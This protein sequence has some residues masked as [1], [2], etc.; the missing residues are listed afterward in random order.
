MSPRAGEEANA[1]LLARLRH[2]LQAPELSPAQIR[3]GR[4]LAGLTQRDLAK[5]VGVS[6]S[7]IR[8]WETGTRNPND[9][10]KAALVD[11]LR[12]S[13]VWAAGGLVDPE[14]GEEVSVDAD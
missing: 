4:E 1:E 13:N 7:T 8:C 5:Q 9:A 6:E 14:T 12:L 10:N 2:Q 11:V 3:R